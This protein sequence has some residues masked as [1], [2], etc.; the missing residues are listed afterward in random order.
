MELFY[1]IYHEKYYIDDESTNITTINSPYSIFKEL[2]EKVRPFIYKKTTNM[3]SPISAKE[4]LA[5]TLRY[6]ATE[7]SLSSLKYQ[8]RVH[9][10][11]IGKFIIPVCEAIYNVLAPDYMKCPSA[12]EE[13]EYIIDRTNSRWQFPNCYAAA[14]GKHIGIICSKNCGSQ[15]YN[16]KGFFRIV[17]LAFVDYDYKFLIAEVGYQGR[18]SDGGVFINSAFNL[19]L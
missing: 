16:Y 15:F 4:K 7:E 12:K 6:L 8:L 5:I 13:W 18:I 1:F 3:R 14:D 19:A 10:T 9:E 11:T 2:L 17:L